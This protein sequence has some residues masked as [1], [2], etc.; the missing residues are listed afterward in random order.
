MHLKG[1]EPGLLEVS[2]SGG[3]LEWGTG[4]QVGMEYVGCQGSHLDPSLLCV[5]SW[6]VVLLWLLC[7]TTIHSSVVVLIQAAPTQ[8]SGDGLPL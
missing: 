8:R 6:E 5:L 2:L 3:E 7:G 1:L 4:A